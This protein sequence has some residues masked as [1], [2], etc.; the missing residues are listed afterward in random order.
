MVIDHLFNFFHS[1]KRFYTGLYLPGFRGFGPESLDKPFGL[2]DLML[3][4]GKGISLDLIAHFLF[5]EIKA[6]VAVVQI[7]LLSRYLDDLFDGVV[8][9]PPVMGNHD[10]RSGIVS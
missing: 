7:Q 8:Q 1:L 2:P 10:Y 5:F 9:K 4:V 6:V 3:L